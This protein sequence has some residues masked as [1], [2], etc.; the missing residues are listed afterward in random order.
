MPTNGVA[1]PSIDLLAAPRLTPPCTHLASHRDPA[2][3]PQLSLIDTHHTHTHTEKTVMHVDERERES[4]TKVDRHERE[5][6]LELE[7]FI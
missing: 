6:E 5:L 4:R 7:N 3:L 1:F 2:K